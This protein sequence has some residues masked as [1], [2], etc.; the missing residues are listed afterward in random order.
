VNFNGTTLC[1]AMLLIAVIELEVAGPYLLMDHC[2]ASEFDHFCG[3]AVIFKRDCYGI[4][5]N[6]LGQLTT[7][8]YQTLL[9]T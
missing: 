6:I 7:G 2:R 4:S 5:I 9:S 8:S 1:D 3:R